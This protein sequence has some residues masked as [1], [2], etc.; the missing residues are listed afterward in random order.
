MEPSID[1]ELAHRQWQQRE[2]RL[3]RAELGFAL[4][5]MAALLYMI[6]SVFMQ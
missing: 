1:I 4:A 5:G 2:L 3:Q 6:L